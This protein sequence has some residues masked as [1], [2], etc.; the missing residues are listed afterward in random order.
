MAI[1]MR[2]GNLAYLDKSKL[3]AGEFVVATDN[4]KDYVGI[5]KAPSKV[6]ELATMQD[7]L[8]VSQV[9]VR[10][11]CFVYG[12]GWKKEADLPISTYSGCAVVYQGKIHYFGGSN[13]T[14]AHLSYNGS[15]WTVEDDLPV[16]MEAPSAIVFDGVVHLFYALKHY[17]WDGEDYTQL[18]DLPDIVVEGNNHAVIYNNDLCL[19]SSNSGHYGWW[20]YLATWDSS[21]DSWTKQNLFDTVYYSAVVFD[22]KIYAI[23]DSSTGGKKYVV[24]DGLSLSE[25]LDLPY[26]YQNGC[27][28]T[29]NEK[30]HL[31]GTRNGNITQKHYT[32]D[33]TDWV[34]AS[35]VPFSFYRGAACVYKNKIHVM[36]TQNSNHITE[37]WSYIGG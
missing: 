23:G 35:D 27:A 31:L 13:S 14:K 18:N 36:S 4:D 24:W 30:I 1:Q 19:V 10:N 15:V 21:E 37:H 6:I 3:T 20:R 34:Q 28:L 29:Y 5:A 16:A 33:G 11:G 17:T 12:K 7:I 25:Q 2:R 8:N 9:I 22:N 32:F 26:G